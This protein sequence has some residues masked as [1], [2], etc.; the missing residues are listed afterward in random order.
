MQRSLKHKGKTQLIFS[1]KLP[2]LKKMQLLCP[3][4]NSFIWLVDIKLKPFLPKKLFAS[5][6][7][8]GLFFIFVRAGENLKTLKRLEGVLEQIQL[9]KGLTSPYCFV[10]LG[11]GSLG[12]F[13]GFLA[14]IFHRGQSLIHIPSTYLSALDSSHGGKTALNYKGFKNQLGSFYSA[15]VTLIVSE[16]IR[17]QGNDGLFNGL[18][19][20]L[21]MAFINPDKT[22]RAILA[23]Q[24]WQHADFI[25]FLPWG[26]EQ[27]MKLVKRD[28]LEKR[29]I[30]VLLN[31]G[32]TLAHVL[33]RTQKL[34]HGQ[35]VLIG[36]YYNILWSHELGLISKK[37]KEKL[38]LNPLF[39]LALNDCK[40]INL[41]DFKKA[42]LLDKKLKTDKILEPFICYPKKAITISVS[43]NDCFSFF[44]SVGLV[45][46]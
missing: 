10:S 39:A 44:I 11:G 30:R 16:L 32:H 42:L 43:L 41:R 7:N 34:P 4:V 22:G 40:K 23:Q 28:P 17:Q 31:L 35:S 9:L 8:K 24:K 37:Q 21:K 26:I 15:D 1:G 14:S 3:S 33:E 46:P 45:K 12:D 18:G 20:L 2:S 25:N 27:K 19:E 29:G 13:T 38:L 5:K 36:L 6:K